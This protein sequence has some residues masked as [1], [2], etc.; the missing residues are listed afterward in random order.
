M[1]DFTL[2]KARAKPS[3]DAAGPLT[4][5]ALWYGG[6]RGTGTQCQ[7]TRIVTGSRPVMRGDELRRLVRYE[8]HRL[9]TEVPMREI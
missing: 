3:H 7:E 9:V 5:W 1:I 6:L 4:A 2:L 8:P